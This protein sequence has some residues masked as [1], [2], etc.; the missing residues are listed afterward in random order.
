MRRD[1][2]TRTI[3]GTEVTA[4]VINSATKEVKTTVITL[5]KIFKDDAKLTKAVAKC[6]EAGE[7]LVSIDSK[8]Q[9]DKCYGL[10]VTAFMAHAIE[11][12]PKTR[13]ALNKEAEAP[14]E[15]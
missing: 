11:L 14:T 15:A 13:E 9:I 2:V 8:T 5:G 1:L 7:V 12:D 10:P 3:T 6:L 4:T